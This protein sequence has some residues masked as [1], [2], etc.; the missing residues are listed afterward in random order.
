MERF[1]SERQV[2]DTLRPELAE[3]HEGEYAV[4]VE[5]ALLGVF[6]TARDAYREGLRRA[7]LDRPFYMERIAPRREPV[8]IH[9][10]R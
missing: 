5:G 8:Y 10:V 2:L 4:V 7:G 3:R 9:G 6:K 1:H